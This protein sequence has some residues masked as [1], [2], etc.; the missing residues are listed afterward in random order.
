MDALVIFM[1]QNT[2]NI[3]AVIK[4]NAVNTVKGPQWKTANPKTL[5]QMIDDAYDGFIG[6]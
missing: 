2:R 3:R 1:P 5:P 6:S 4:V